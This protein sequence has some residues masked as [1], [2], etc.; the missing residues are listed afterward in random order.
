V[1]KAAGDA[2]GIGLAV[3]KEESNMGRRRRSGFTLVELLV[4]IGVIAVLVGL[5][6]PALVKARKASGRTRCLSNLH[7]IAVAYQLYLEEH[8]QRVMRVNPLPTEK[9]LV[10]DKTPSLVE[11]LNP[12][13]GKRPLRLTPTGVPAGNEVFRCPTDQLSKKDSDAGVLTFPANV[14]VTTYFDA[15]GS[16]YEYNFYFNASA[17]DPVTGVNRVWSQALANARSPRQFVPLAPV[18]LPLLLDFESFHGPPNQMQSRNAMFADF[19]AE[20]LSI[21]LTGPVKGLP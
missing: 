8:Q 3:T 20:V 5:L 13:L 15:E 11:V 6:L 1:L 7:N 10:P 16:S 21:T 19:H 17:V 9:G 18:D 4:V 12:Y 14:I 2:C